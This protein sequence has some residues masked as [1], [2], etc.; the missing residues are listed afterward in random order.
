MQ[1]NT[2]VGGR[3]LPRCAHT[4]SPQVRYEDD[5][6]QLLQGDWRVVKNGGWKEPESMCRTVFSVSPDG[7]ESQSPEADA[8]TKSQ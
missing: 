5:N 3:A 1:D 4:P 7:S 2:G 6:S 8:V